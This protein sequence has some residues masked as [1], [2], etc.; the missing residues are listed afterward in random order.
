MLYALGVVPPTDLIEPET[1]RATLRHVMATW[2][3]ETTWGWDYPAIAMTAT[4]LGEPETALA[5]LL[6]PT[7][8]NTYLLNGHNRQTASLPVY[9]PGNGGLLAAVALMAAGWDGSGPTPGFPADG[10]WTV[11]HEGLLPLP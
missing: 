6:M 11:R 3:W 2:P 9:L 1:M 7:A 5:A 4:R 8:K 10:S